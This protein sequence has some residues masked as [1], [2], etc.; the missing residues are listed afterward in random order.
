MSFKLETKEDVIKF[1]TKDNINEVN[2]VGDTLLMIASDYGRTEV[3][4]ELIK[5]GADINIQ[6]I[7]KETALCIACKRGYI[8]IIDILLENKANVNISNN[9]SSTALHF[10]CLNSQFDAVLK[11]LHT[12]LVNINQKDIYGGTALFNACSYAGSIEIVDQLLC[13]G[14]DPHIINNN[15]N[16]SLIFSCYKN[17][18][19]ITE[20]MIE[21]CVSINHQNN[22]RKT[23]LHIACYH[24]SIDCIKILLQN[25]ADITIIDENGK[26]AIDY[27]RDKT[28]FANYK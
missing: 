11:L 8:D 14:F 18:F 17:K 21:M 6:D 28:V 7:Y 12:N 22:I 4:L 26:L 16:T 9:Y 13:Y 5:L 20:R 2:N 10:A 25:S 3:V 15:G 23:A 24:N 1:I 27:L 19:K